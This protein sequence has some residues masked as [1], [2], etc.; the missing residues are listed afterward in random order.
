MTMQKKTFTRLPVV[1]ALVTVLPLVALGGDESYN[2]IVKHIKTSYNAKQQGF[3]G[4]MMLARLAVKIVKP[5]GVKNFKMTL[6]RDLDYSHAAAPEDGHFHSF[7]RSNIDPRWAPLVE[8]SSPR[9]RQWSYVYVTRENE[10]IKVLVITLQ[11]HDAVVLQ[12]KFSPE[13]LAEFMNNPQIMG[14][15]LNSDKKT[16]DSS[17]KPEETGGDNDADSQK[18]KPASEKPPQVNQP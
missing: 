4:A 9:E 13:K 8:Y 7:I 3:F 17:V 14:I 15:S 2:S 10:D 1:V 5:A 12:T 6:L 18:Q 16:N 11:Q